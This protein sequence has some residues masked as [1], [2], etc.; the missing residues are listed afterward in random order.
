MFVFLVLP[1]LD[2]HSVYKE[3]N[4]LS[5]DSTKESSSFENAP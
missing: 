3:A 5:S 4:H 1:A 2:A